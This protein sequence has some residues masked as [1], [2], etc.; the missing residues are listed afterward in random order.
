MDYTGFILC[1]FITSCE[2]W[3]E[4]LQLGVLTPSLSGFGA[5]NTLLLQELLQSGV[6]TP[7]AT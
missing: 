4:L 3:Q 5:E 1:A 7:E 6:L 2:W